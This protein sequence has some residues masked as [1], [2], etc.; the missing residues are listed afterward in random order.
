MTQGLNLPQR[1]R[2]VRRGHAT[3]ACPRNRRSLGLAVE[4]LSARSFSSKSSQFFRF[5]TLICRST[6]TSRRP[7]RE[8]KLNIEKVGWASRAVFEQSSPEVR[9]SAPPFPST[10]PSPAARLGATGTRARRRG[11]RDE[12]LSAC[13]AVAS[14]DEAGVATLADMG[15]LRLHCRAAARRAAGELRAVAASP[16]RRSLC[17]RRRDERAAAVAVADARPRSRSDCA[18]A[19]VDSFAAPAASG[20]RFF[21]PGRRSAAVWLLRTFVRQNPS[22]NRRTVPDSFTPPATTTR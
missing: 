22:D 3:S 9:L 21:R 16:A 11:T 14:L 4:L 12:R 18:A 20:L 5:I 19:G 2:V 8:R 6:E 17:A 10:L 1:S 7:P 15:L 13:A